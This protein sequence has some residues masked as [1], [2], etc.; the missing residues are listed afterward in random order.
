MEAFEPLPNAS[1]EIP[2]LDG[3]PGLIQD[4][5]M[6]LVTSFHGAMSVS[7]AYF[8]EKISKSYGTKNERFTHSTV[9]SAA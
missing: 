2:N 1:A 7:S 9:F 5:F 8:E 6:E 3:H 4:F